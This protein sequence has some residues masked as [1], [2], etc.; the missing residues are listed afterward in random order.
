VAEWAAG[1]AGGPAQLTAR[2]ARVEPC[3]V[4]AGRPAVLRL[5]GQELRSP[6]VL[7]HVRCQGRYLPHGGLGGREGGG[8]E[9][10]EVSLP[11]VAMPGRVQLELEQ[12][13]LVGE[14]LPLLAVPDAGMARELQRLGLQLEAADMAQVGAGSCAGAP[15]RSRGCRL[16]CGCRP[17]SSSSSS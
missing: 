6:G 7:L 1:E 10:E 3:A 2:L 14:A 9:E 17:S 11:A 16:P 4:V 15:I 5:S 12:R 8:G 13:L